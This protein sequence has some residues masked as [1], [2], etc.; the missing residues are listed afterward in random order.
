MEKAAIAGSDAVPENSRGAGATLIMSAHRM[1]H[2]LS[3]A[4]YSILAWG[5]LLAASTSR[6]VSLW[7]ASAHLGV[8]LLKLA[9]QLLACMTIGGILY[10]LCK[11]A[12]LAEVPTALCSVIVLSL[13]GNWETLQGRTA[14]F[15]LIAVGVGIWLVIRLAGSGPLPGGAVIL[16]AVMG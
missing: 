15:G 2:Y 6:P 14:E 10:S 7:A 5:V 4:R 8:S 16:I 12:K 9:L 11:W 3:A 13:I 1:A